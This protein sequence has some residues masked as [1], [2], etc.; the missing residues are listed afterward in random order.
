M[1]RKIAL[2]GSR[3]L[4]GYTGVYSMIDHIITLELE[5]SGSFTLVNGG[6]DGVDSMAGE[7]ASSRGLDYEV[8]PLKECRSGCVPGK[9]YC[10]EHSYK[11]RSR[12]IAS[13]AEK[14]YRVYDEG[15]GVST[16]EV[17]ARFGEELGKSVERL[18]VDLTIL[19]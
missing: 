2:V 4:E 19:H 11:P 16:C 15:C 17:T 12:E 14:I 6:E 18:S 7:I 8:V 1:P 10:F 5:R 9:N 13:Q 3:S